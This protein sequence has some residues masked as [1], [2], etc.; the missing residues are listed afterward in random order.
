MPQGCS[1]VREKKVSDV[2]VCCCQQVSV[3]LYKKNSTGYR[4]STCVNKPGV[5]SDDTSLSR[6]HRWELGTSPS[7]HFPKDDVMITS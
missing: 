2:E 5:L 7:L 4:T 1:K 3:F 6:R